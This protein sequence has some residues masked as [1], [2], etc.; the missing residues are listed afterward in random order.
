MI[1]YRIAE[2]GV[3]LW[4]LSGPTPPCSSRDYNHYYN[5]LISI[6]DSVFT[7]EWEFC[8]GRNAEV[9]S[10]FI[11]TELLLHYKFFSYKYKY[12]FIFF[13]WKK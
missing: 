6:R 2:F 11:P 13:R 1:G 4:R 8:K 7:L 10:I 3:D 12:I 5:A 9:S